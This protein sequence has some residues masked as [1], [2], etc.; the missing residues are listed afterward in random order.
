MG[1]SKVLLPNGM[2]FD[3]P[4][5]CQLG[6]KNFQIQCSRPIL[7]LGRPLDPSRLYSQIDHNYGS[8]QTGESLYRRTENYFKELYE[9]KI[10]GGDLNDI[11]S[12]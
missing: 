12:P 8:P 4:P 3:L 9:E 2:Y 7:Y 10:K 5:S 6:R 11:P 1:D